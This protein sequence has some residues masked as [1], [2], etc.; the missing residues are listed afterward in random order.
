V[1]LDSEYVEDEPRADLRVQVD[2]R[3]QHGVVDYLHRLGCSVD[4]RGGGILEVRVSYPETV[5]DEEAAIAEWCAS[6]SAAHGPVRAVVTGTTRP[7]VT[8]VRPLLRPAP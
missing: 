4:D 7:D 5:E 3:A 6:W 2:P 1:P 8:L